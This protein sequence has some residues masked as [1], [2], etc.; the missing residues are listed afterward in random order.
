VPRVLLIWMA[1]IYFETPGFGRSEMH[2]IANPSEC[3]ISCHVSTSINSPN[4][5][6][7]WDFGSS[8]FT[9]PAFFRS[10]Y[11]RSRISCRVS[12]WF[13][14][15][16]FTSELWASGVPRCKSP[17]YE[18]TKYG[19]RLTCVPRSDQRTGIARNSLYLLYI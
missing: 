12:S 1:E 6:G 15:K 4:E 8:C 17:E 5:L 11:P 10:G 2:N 16:K 19:D 14:W 13:Q 18:I 3:R 9:H 7:F